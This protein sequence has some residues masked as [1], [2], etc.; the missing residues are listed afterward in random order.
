MTTRELTDSVPADAIQLV[1]EAATE[2]LLKRGRVEIDRF[3]A[4]ELV[5]RKPRY[6]R[7]PRT[8]ALVEVPAKTAVR[9]VPARALKDRAAPITEVT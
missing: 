5:R 8:G 4:F 3:G 6:A 1:F 2:V 9:F 7:N